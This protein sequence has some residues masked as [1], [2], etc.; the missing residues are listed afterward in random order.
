MPHKET[1]HVAIGYSVPRD[2]RDCGPVL[3]RLRRRHV[4]RRGEDPVLHFPVLAVLS[5]LG[6]MFRGTPPPA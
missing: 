4:V 3:V 5:F 2:R 1:H 6:G